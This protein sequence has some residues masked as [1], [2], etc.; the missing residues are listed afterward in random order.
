MTMN[1]DFVHRWEPGSGS[2]TVLL[3][4]GTGGDENDLLSLGRT[5]A[6]EASFLSPRGKV[7]E[8]GMPRFFRRLSEGVFDLEDLRTRTHEL[9][10]WID[11]A[12]GRY[13]FDPATL[14][15]LG[16]SN[17][18][19]IAASL[20]LLRPE[21]LSG[22]ILLRAMLPFEPEKVPDLTRKKIL[23]ANGRNDPII[24]I[25]SSARLAEILKAAGADVTQSITDGGHGLEQ[26]ELAAARDW[27]RGNRGSHP[28]RA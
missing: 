24:P 28:V 20:L 17:G 22:A 21:C 6:P 25:A 10:E 13:K 11:T 5:V 3:L 12:S 1:T 2:E 7:L 14:V 16:Y 19:N 9:A 4:H 23:M 18:A 27:Y 15:A 26:S 8:R